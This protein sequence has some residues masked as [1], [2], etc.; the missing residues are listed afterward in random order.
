MTVL[1]ILS[2]AGRRWRAAYGV[3]AGT[4]HVTLE[5]RIRREMELTADSEL[6]VEAVL[7]DCLELAIAWN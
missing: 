1:R 6:T 5:S 2:L 7:G 4:G 3:C